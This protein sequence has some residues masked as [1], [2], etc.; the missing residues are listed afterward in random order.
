MCVHVCVSIVASFY[1]VEC[2]KADKGASSGFIGNA[3]PP[4]GIVVCDFWGYG[5]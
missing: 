1:V 4:L 3:T 2:P 5:V